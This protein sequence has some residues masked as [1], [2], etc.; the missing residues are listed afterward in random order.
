MQSKLLT[1]TLTLLI[2][3]GVAYIVY[4]NYVK[5]TLF[6]SGDII[7]QTAL[8]SQHQ[9]IRIATK[10]K[11]SHCGIIYE[12][13]GIFYVY[14]AAQPVKITPLN[15]W[16][17]K[18]E[19]GSYT[20]KRLKNADK[21]LT[22]QALA[23]IAAECEKHLGKDHDFISQWSDEKMY[24]SEYVWKVFDRAL[25]IQLGELQKI[26]DFDLESLLNIA[27]AQAILESLFG[28]INNIPLDETIISPVAICNSDLLE[29]IKDT[30]PGI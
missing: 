21:I 1:I 24:S 11:Y 6:Q 18:G 5:K 29:T 8:T 23:K 25:G 10:S 13:D 30:Y 15:Q 4:E 7:F 26:G 27:Q 28:G 16:I 9:I 12:K 20:L 14:E 19:H 2:L 3:A 17:A 22:P